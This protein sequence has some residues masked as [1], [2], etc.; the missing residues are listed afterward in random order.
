M[1]PCMLT[2]V[3]LSHWHSQQSSLKTHSTLSAAYNICPHG[4]AGGLIPH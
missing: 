1:Y 4:D 2:H 3:T